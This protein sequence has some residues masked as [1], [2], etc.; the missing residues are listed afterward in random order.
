MQLHCC[1]VSN[2]TDWKETAYFKE[3]GIPASC[4]KDNTKCSPETLKDPDKA[5]TEVYTT[6]SSVPQSAQFYVLKVILNLVFFCCVGLLHTG[7]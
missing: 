5:Q 3:N 1:G 4:C 2:Y 7:D 6:V